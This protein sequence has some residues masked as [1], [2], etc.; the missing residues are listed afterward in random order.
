MQHASFAAMDCP[1]ALSLERVGEWWSILILRDVFHG[2]TRFDQ[3]RKSLGIAPNILSRRLHGLVEAGLLTK[4]RYSEHPPRDEYRLT[5]R[6][7]DF[8][9]VLWALLAWGNKHFMP[10]GQALP[11]MDAATGLPVEPVMVDANTGKQMDQAVFRSIR[12]P[13]SNAD[14]RKQ[15]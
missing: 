11:L 2:R 15:P 14:I 6:G 12:R 8:R 10:E 3:F 1:I 9:P 7:R 5:E 13:P 4:S